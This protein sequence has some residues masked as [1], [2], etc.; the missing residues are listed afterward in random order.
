MSTPN[1][2]PFESFT[3]DSITP[4]PPACNSSEDVE[5]D[6][7]CDMQQNVIKIIAL[8]NKSPEG[9]TNEC[10][11]VNATN[12]PP[13]TPPKT[14]NTVQNHVNLSDAIVQ[15]S[16]EGSTAA[17]SHTATSGPSHCAQ[18]AH[19]LSN[20]K[21]KNNNACLISAPESVP[22]ATDKLKTCQE[23]DNSIARNASCEKHCLARGR[24]KKALLC[25]RYGIV[26]GGIKFD[27]GSV[28]ACSK[29]PQLDLKKKFV[30]EKRIL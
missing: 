16:C 26:K 9:K 27:Y 15:R 14:N 20:E 11:N 2:H 13:T 12:P 6:T 28:D 1:K 25:M 24:S 21:P 22:T 3:V 18:L 8:L 4:A 23:T 17:Y 10:S 5:E 30:P 29:C 19:H 7:S